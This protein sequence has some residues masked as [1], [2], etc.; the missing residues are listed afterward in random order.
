VTQRQTPWY[1][2]MHDNPFDTAVRQEINLCK[3]AAMLCPQGEVTE[4]YLRTTADLLVKLDVDPGFRAQNQTSLR[5]QQ[6]SS[7]ESIQ[8]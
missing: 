6:L 1:A 3:E 2:A 8:N 5:R 7:S 4:F